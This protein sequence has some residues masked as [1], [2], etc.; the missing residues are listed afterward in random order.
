MSLWTKS[1]TIRFAWEARVSAPRWPSGVYDK[2]ERRVE[3]TPTVSEAVADA[4]QNAETL[5][6]EGSDVVVRDVAGHDSSLA[7]TRA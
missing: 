4:F 2:A 3:L 6:A 5:L 7:T 1:G